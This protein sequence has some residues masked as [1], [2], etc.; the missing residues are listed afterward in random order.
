MDNLQL[1]FPARI[2]F[3]NYLFFI[4]SIFIS[5]ICL[6]E[7]GQ[8]GSTST[9]TAH[10]SIVIPP[11]NEVQFNSDG[12]YKINT[13]LPKGEYEEIVMSETETKGDIVRIIILRPKL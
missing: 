5:S 2:T 10:I 3:M 4:L 9:A 1:K 11:R 6:A 13:N 7:D 12:S 8:L